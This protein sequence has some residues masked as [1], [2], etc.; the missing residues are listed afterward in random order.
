[1]YSIQS[2]FLCLVCSLFIFSS[3]QGTKQKGKKEK[4]V[5]VVRKVKKET[6]EIE[7]TFN[8]VFVDA[9]SDRVINQAGFDALNGTEI[10]SGIKIRPKVQLRKAAGA[11]AEVS[12]TITTSL[13]RQFEFRRKGSNDRFNEIRFTANENAEIL[14]EF[15]EWEVFPIGVPPDPPLGNNASIAEQII[16]TISLKNENEE[17]SDTHAVL[18]KWTKKAGNTPSPPQTRAKKGKFILQVSTARVRTSVPIFP[19]PVPAKPQTK[20][21]HTFP[22]ALYWKVKNP[23]KCPCAPN[24]KYKVVQFAKGLIEIDRDKP[25]RTPW[26]I[27]TKGEQQDLANQDKN[28]DPSFTLDPFDLDPNDG[29]DHIRPVLCPAGKPAIGQFDAPGVPESIFNILVGKSGSVTQTFRAFLI[30]HNPAAYDANADTPAEF[31]KM[32]VV[33]EMAYEIRYVFQR[34]NRNPLSVNI[35]GFKYTKHNCKRRNLGDFIKGQFKAGYEKPITR[36]TQDP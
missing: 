4:L 9:V 26:H 32:G 24:G 12:L 16:A 18:L 10:F 17:C 30:C 36:F 3:C 5:S 7:T 20:T 28:Y 14:K 8:L 31:L 35:T 34:N 33:A 27:D 21:V 2:A 22:L 23:S 19:K 11:P 6:C 25:Y 29:T 13:G 15:A 1:M